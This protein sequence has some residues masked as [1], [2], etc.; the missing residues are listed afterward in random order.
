V[1]ARAETF[2]ACP[3]CRQGIPIDLDTLPACSPKEHYEQCRKLAAAHDERCARAY[4]E[5]LA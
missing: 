4:A 1:T 5:V 3:C 2:L